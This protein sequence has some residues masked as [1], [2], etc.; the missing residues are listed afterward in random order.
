MTAATPTPTT[1]GTHQGFVPF[2]VFTPDRTI[3]QFAEISIAERW[4]GG[5][6]IYLADVEKRLGFLLT[7][8][9]ARLWAKALTQAADALEAKG[10]KP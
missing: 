10:G 9:D 6:A 5:W 8:Y 7:T 2:S 4:P 3:K 1:A